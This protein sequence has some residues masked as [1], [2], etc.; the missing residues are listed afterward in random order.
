MLSHLL[1]WIQYKIHVDY[2][3]IYGEYKRCLD[4][5]YLFFFLKCFKALGGSFKKCKV[6]RMYVAWRHMHLILNPVYCS[7]NCM[8]V[9][10]NLFYYWLKDETRMVCMR[11]QR[12]RVI[13]DCEIELSSRFWLLRLSSLFHMLSWYADRCSPRL[14]HTRWLCSCMD[15]WTTL[16]FIRDGSE[17][18]FREVP[19]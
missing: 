19:W 4:Q 5:F 16:L 7:Q 1:L 14:S 8:C 9:S 6:R 3:Y 13:N 2:F 17:E 11:S 18:F 15:I 12:S 10:E